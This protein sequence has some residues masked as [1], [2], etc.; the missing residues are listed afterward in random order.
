VSVGLVFGAMFSCVHAIWIS[1]LFADTAFALG[2]L[3]AQ[4]S[5]PPPH[6]VSNKVKPIANVKN[7]NFIG[8]VRL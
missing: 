4:S 7:V 3:L 8:F 5:P 1:K 2:S 6:P